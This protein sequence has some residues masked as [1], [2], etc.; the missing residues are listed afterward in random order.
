MTPNTLSSTATANGVP[1]ALAMQVA[2]SSRSRGSEPFCSVTNFLIASTAPLRIFVPSVKL[3]PDIRVSAVNSIISASRYSRSDQLA[4]RLLASST[5][6]RPSGVSSFTDDCRAA[7]VASCFDTPSI[8]MNS[9]A[10][11][12]PK[13]IVPVLSRIIVSMSPAASTALPDMASTLKRVTR[14]IPAIP[15]A[16]NRPPMVVGM[17]QTS[18]AMSVAISNVTFR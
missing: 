2:L 13:V 9:A 16:D 12:F 15:I 8:G 17:R 3:S 18:N 6:E 1:P 10:I 11:R 5:I 4:S 7:N 14:F